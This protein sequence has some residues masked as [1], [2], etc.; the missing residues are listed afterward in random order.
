MNALLQQFLPYL[1][2][3]ITRCSLQP[4]EPAQ[5]AQ[6]NDRIERQE[7][8]HTDASAV[9]ERLTEA[10]RSEDG[11][12]I[13]PIVDHQIV[14][15]LESLAI[16]SDSEN[17]APQ[18]LDAQ[19]KIVLDFYNEFGWKKDEDNLFKDTVAFED[20][21]DTV[22]RYWS[23]CHLRLNRYLPANGQY[24]LDVASG[25]I[26]NDE[27]LTYSDHFEVRICMDF[28]LLA[29][30]EAVQRL[31]G[32]GI[33]ILGD[34]TNLPMADQ[35]L[36]AVISLHTVYHIPKAEQTQAVREA[37]RVLRLGG[38][39]VI[40]YSWKDAPLMYR[41][42]RAWR[43][44]MSFVRRL[45]GQRSQ[46]ATGVP[47]TGVPATGVPA[48]G[49]PAT[50]VP[51]TGVPATGVP[52]TGVPATGV[53]ATGVPATGVPA[54][55]VPATGVPATGVPATGVPATGV[56]A[57]GVPA[58][59]VPATGVPATGVPA[60]GVPA[61][62]VPATGVPATGVPATGVPATGVPAT[63]V[64]AT[65][66]PAT[67]VPATGVP[68]TGVPATGVPATGVPATGVPATGVPATGVPATGVPATGVPATGV[69]ATGVPATGVPATGV[70]ATGVPAT[71]VPAH[72]ELFI[73]Q[74]KYDWYAR[75][76]HQPFNAQLKVY[77]AL[78]RSFSNTFLRE[79]T[80]GKQVAGLIYRLEGWLPGFFGRFGQ[81]PTFV[82]HK[83]TDGKETMAA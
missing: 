79:K 67:G 35:C 29:M 34:M 5:L 54:T 32:R 65:G 31:N 81:Y 39:A 83:P 77:S 69:P 42:M 64:P 23:Q 63:G 40:V 75:E 48:T 78:S 11:Q 80:F 45:R 33:F 43:R 44:L 20:R 55:G 68:A 76:L 27:Y 49:V 37:Y 62:G 10:L 3:P 1:R 53:P 52:A 7:L 25:A 21:R 18:A 71:G 24:I 72:P 14:V 38:K 12:Y 57:T 2:C 28:S 60:T 73:D 26:P 66:V 19:K 82:L 9:P 58:T 74:Q 61:T 59:G 15:L 51:A 56:P 36:D 30:Q 6:L 17:T 16:V 8:R 47:A 4:V 22:A 70:P 50:G 13:Y 41:S 46:G